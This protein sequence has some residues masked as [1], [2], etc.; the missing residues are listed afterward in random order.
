[1]RERLLVLRRLGAFMVTTL[2]PALVSL[3]AMPVIIR[4]AGAHTWGVQSSV[5]SAAMLFGVAVG[6]GWSAT[7]AAETARRPPAERPQWFI[8][9]LVSRIF[10][11]CLTAPL[12]VL[13]MWLINRD[14]LGLVVV[15]SLAYLV[16]YVGAD[17]YFVGEARPSRLFRL[18]ALPQTT[19]LALSV[20]AMLLT[21]S[22]V[23]TVAVQLL[24][25]ICAVILSVSAIVK[26]S[27][28]VLHFDWSISR[29]LGRLIAQRDPFVTAA[30]S[31]LYVTSPMLIINLF[32]PGALALY[33]MGDKLFKSSLTVFAPVLQVVQGWLP[34]G[35]PKNLVH[36]IKQA[37]RLSPLVS[38]AGAACI[39]LLGPWFARI[40]S[41]GAID[42]GFDISLPFAVIFAAVSVTQVFGLAFLVQLGRSAA[43]AKSTVVGAVI[44]VPMIIAGAVLFAAHGVA[45]AV[46]LSE[47]TV[48]IYQLAVV[49][50]ELRR[51]RATT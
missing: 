21:N 6:F 24:A 15:G 41:Q 23:V 45:W 12:M 28:E 10:L 20:V 50:A 27:P 43:L 49:I 40:L 48:L 22:I 38:I 29:A 33:A 44:G 25:N 36:R 37:A 4:G 30:T 35:G 13:V 2:M 8:D 39:F 46:A 16:P 11:F 32:Q 17:W 14:Y 7:G 51:R 19:G 34:E 5:Q 42:F 31:A 26:S 9:S 18:N 47:I 1:M 3:V